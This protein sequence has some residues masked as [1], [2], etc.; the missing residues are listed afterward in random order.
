MSE[1]ISDDSGRDISSYLLKHAIESGHR[2]IT[3]ENFKIINNGFRNNTS[4]RKIAE[5][6]LI[7]E[8]KPTLKKQEHSLQLKLYN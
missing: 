5:S 2:H 7:K 6:L 3:G 1:R 4:K 8:K